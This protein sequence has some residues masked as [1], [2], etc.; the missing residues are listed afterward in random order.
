MCVCGVC[1]WL[2]VCVCVCVVCVCVSFRA[3][4]MEAYYYVSGEIR[5]QTSILC[6]HAKDDLNA[7]VRTVK[8]MYTL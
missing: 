7:V 2:C 4:Q 6:V 8:Q 1:E 5:S 3:L